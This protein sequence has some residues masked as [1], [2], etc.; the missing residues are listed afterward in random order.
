MRNNGIHVVGRLYVLQVDELV[1]MRIAGC[2]RRTRGGATN[3]LGYDWGRNASILRQ[4][5][6]DRAS[7]KSHHSKHR[8]YAQEYES[9]H[10]LKSGN[11]LLHWTLQ[12]DDRSSDVDAATMPPG[13]QV[14]LFGACN[15]RVS[16]RRSLR[17][18]RHHETVRTDGTRQAMRHSTCRSSRY[19]CA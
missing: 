18:P 17:Y 11:S 16:R 9:R 7:D 1:R 6:R 2:G 3:I 15:L 4:T 19:R 5:R 10:D 8:D 12:P 13:F 14:R